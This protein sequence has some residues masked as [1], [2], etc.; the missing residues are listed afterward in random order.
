MSQ[1]P[2]NE[3]IENVLRKQMKLL[4]NDNLWRATT[5]WQ[6]WRSPPFRMDTAV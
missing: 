2:H 4:P 1:L 6:N 5:A 3:I